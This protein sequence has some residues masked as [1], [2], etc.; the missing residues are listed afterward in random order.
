LLVS[1]LHSVTRV[2][3]GTEVGIP[4]GLLINLFINIS[5]CCLCEEQSATARQARLRETKF[6]EDASSLISDE[7]NVIL[8]SAASTWEI[9]TKVLIGK[10]FDREVL[11]SCGEA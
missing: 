10:A 7:A 3:N 9:V 4:L 6:Y 11:F 8:V 1:T 2:H 5:R